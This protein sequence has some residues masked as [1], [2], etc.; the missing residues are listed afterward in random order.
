M[1]RFKDRAGNW[2]NLR[3]CAAGRFGQ[4]HYRVDHHVEDHAVELLLQDSVPVHQTRRNQP[5]GTRY[6]YAKK[7]HIADI[8]IIGFMAVTDW[9]PRNMLPTIRSL[10]EALHIVLIQPMKR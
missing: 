7:F 5:S 10:V 3:G 9:G 1:T 2:N 8:D 4:Q 6:F